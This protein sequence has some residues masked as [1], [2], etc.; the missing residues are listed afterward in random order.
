MRLSSPALETHL[1]GLGVRVVVRCHGSRAAELHSAVTEVWADCAV[2]PTPDAAVIDVLL[3]EDPDV[4]A[5]ARTSGVTA[6]TSLPNLLHDLSPV[7]TQTVI[8]ANA[9]G[10]LMLHSAG[11]CHPVSGACVALVAPSGTGKTTATRLLTQE[12]GYVSDETIGVREDLSVASY[13]KPLS[14]LESAG[15]PIKTQRPVS[16]LGLR[17][18]PHDLRLIGVLL[19]ERDPAGPELE[20]EPVRTVHALAAL[21]PQTSYLARL[22][23]PL[24]RLAKTLEATG[25][26]RIVRYREAE[27]LRA[28]VDELVGCGS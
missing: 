21:A 26:L 7:I 10:L 12:L 20:V 5:T 28:L 9:G 8:T 2:C 25:G 23:R 3:D 27:R 14:L 18:A 22:D 19:L 1:G 13:R 17:V 4:V 24:H 15:S 6:S 16:S 11:V